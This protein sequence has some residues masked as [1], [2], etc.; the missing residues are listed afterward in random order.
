LLCSIKTLLSRISTGVHKTAAL[1]FLQSMFWSSTLLLP[2]I[3]AFS[4]RSGEKFLFR[5]CKKLFMV[6][7]RMKL[8]WST[9]TVCFGN[10]MDF[11]FWLMWTCIYWFFVRLRKFFVEVSDAFRRF[12]WVKIASK[13]RR[14]AQGDFN[15]SG[16]AVFLGILNRL[17]IWIANIFVSNG[18]RRQQMRN[19]VIFGC[20]EVI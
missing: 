12:R 16:F 5:L 10:D 11:Y 18:L 2:K 19:S 1:S 4:R 3:S 8:F 14:I 15:V 17:Y 6:H 9:S 7:S 20:W 13:F